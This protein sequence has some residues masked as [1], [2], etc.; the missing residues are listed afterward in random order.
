MF[1]FFLSFDLEIAYGF[2]SFFTIIASLPMTQA[3]NTC[4]PF[5]FEKHITLEAKL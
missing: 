4:S 1:L 2:I 5:P 3:A